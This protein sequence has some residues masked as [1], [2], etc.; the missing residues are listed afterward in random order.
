[1]AFAGRN[2][3]KDAMWDRLRGLLFEARLDFPDRPYDPDFLAAARALTNASN[4]LLLDVAEEA[5]TAIESGA[6]RDV[7]DEALIRLA[8][9]SRE[10]NE[11]I[12]GTMIA[13]WNA[14]PRAVAEELF[15]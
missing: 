6:A 11:R 2:Y 15:R 14:R 9:F 8:R 10:E 1:V 12:R 5:L 4:T 7:S 3:G 13:L